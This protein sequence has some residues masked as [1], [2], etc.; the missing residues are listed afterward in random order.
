MDPD[1][2]LEE[3][4]ALLVADLAPLLACHG[5]MRHV[6]QTSSLSIYSKF[7]RTVF[8]LAYVSMIFPSIRIYLVDTI[9]SSWNR[10]LAKILVSPLASR[11]TSTRPRG[12]LLLHMN[13][14]FEALAGI[15]LASCLSRCRNQNLTT[16]FKLMVISD[17]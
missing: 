17:Q 1:A 5:M 4:V 14:V 6:N 9:H 8:K 15:W 11:T 10:F 12:Y 2:F 13:W 7:L 16:H 3:D